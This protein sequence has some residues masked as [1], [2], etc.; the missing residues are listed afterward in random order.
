MTD[1]DEEDER[2][3]GKKIH[4]KRW[5]LIIP[6]FYDVTQMIFDTIWVLSKD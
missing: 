6:H 2:R 5:K 1:Q 4:K 3:S